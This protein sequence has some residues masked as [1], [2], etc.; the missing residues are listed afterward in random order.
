MSSKV[1]SVK[2]LLAKAKNQAR[3]NALVKQKANIN[4]ALKKLQ[5]PK[6][7]PKIT[8]FAAKLKA[9]IKDHKKMNKSKRVSPENAKS[10]SSSPGSAKS[11]ASSRRSS[12]GS[13]KSNASSRRSSPGSAKSNVSRR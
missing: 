1:S 10:K 9:M 5:K 11:N 4:T 12:P 13:A 6:P 7:V 3:F 8:T 2:I